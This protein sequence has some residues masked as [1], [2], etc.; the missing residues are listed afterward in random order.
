M[1]RDEWKKNEA[2]IPEVDYSIAAGTRENVRSGAGYGSAGHQENSDPAAEQI[3][4][5][6]SRSGGSQ[7]SGS[8]GSRAGGYNNQN[9][10]G[11]GSGRS[12]YESQTSG[13]SGGRMDPSAG[14]GASGQPGSQYRPGGFAGS[15]NHQNV[16]FTPNYQSGQM[17]PHNGTDPSGADLNRNTKPKREKKQR[18][19]VSGG[20]KK[21]LSAILIIVL[22]FGAGFGGGA[23]AVNMFGSDGDSGAV[24]NI[25]I[26]ASESGM[27]A[28]SVIA[29]KV[30]PSVVGISTVQKTYTQSIFGVQQGIAEGIGTGF[31]VD[32]DGYILTNSHVVNNGESSKITVDLY[33]GSE[34]EGTVLWND[35]SLD[36]A[37]VKIDAANLRVADLGDSDAVKIGDYAV[38]IG[39]PLGRDFERS[40]TQGII[41]GLDRSIT[42]TDGTNTNNMQGLIQTDASI[43]SGN[44]GGPLINSSGEVIGINTAK[45]SSG[46]GLG[47]AIP[48]NIALPV[49]Q[50]IKENGTY[51]PAYLGIMGMSVEDAMAYYETDFRTDKGVVVTQIYTDSPAARAGM[52]EGDII[53]ALDGEKTDDMS[54]LKKKLVHYR[55]GDTV[56]LTIERNKSDMTLEVTLQAQQE[57]L[58]MQYKESDS[59]YGG[60]NGGGQNGGQ[61]GGYESSDPYRDFFE[62]F[63][64]N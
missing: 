54:A 6:E 56:T 4:Q 23:L 29:E 64:G 43:N 25:S 40:V 27:D 50:E 14:G 46:E 7:E 44:S 59:S 19:P 20:A 26:D 32:E 45:A 8:Y 11:F 30:M 31:I 34:Y 58:T 10:G 2:D 3:R 21:V 38:A 53:K 55:P 41:S 28:A 37:I 57:N 60:Q 33:D 49:I 35:S 62:G 24:S 18:K 15:Q 12:G 63:F 52:K 39:N 13:W 36:L 16:R 17:P 47:F 1:E 48:V 61:G 5:T 9:S 22:S 42:T 51:E